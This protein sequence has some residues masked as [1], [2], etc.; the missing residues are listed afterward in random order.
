M[1][2]KKRNARRT[3][4]LIE[5]DLHP[6]PIEQ[7][8]RW[9]REAE[10]AKMVE[11]TAMALATATKEGKPST[12]IVLLKSLQNG[13]LE[14]YTNYDSRKAGELKENPLAAIVFYWDVLHRQVRIEGHV[15]PMS[16]EESFSYFKTR[17]R[18]SRIGAWA[19]KQSAVISGRRELEEDVKRIEKEYKGKEIP[20]PPFWGGYRLVPTEFEFWQGRENRLHDRLRYSLREGRW[21]IDRL[22]P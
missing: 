6:D 8:K 11:P 4:G 16:R 12:R 5:T 17:P 14:F 3:E 13:S 2:Q 18:M 7:L 20:F 15:S 9:L 1:G 19:S 21:S 10:H 22:S